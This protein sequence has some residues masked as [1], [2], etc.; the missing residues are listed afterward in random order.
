MLKLPGPGHFHPSFPTSN[1][2]FYV[3]PTSHNLVKKK[4]ISSN[5][6]PTTLGTASNMISEETRVL[7]EILVRRVH[8]HLPA[9]VTSY[10]EFD[11]D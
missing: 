2:A 9:T 1:G 11:L 7:I 4:K 10:P 8:R 3:A 5:F 6:I